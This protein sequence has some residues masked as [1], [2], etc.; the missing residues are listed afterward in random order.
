MADKST[1]LKIVITDAN[2]VNSTS[3]VCSTDADVKNMASPILDGILD[4]LGSQIND[5][6][7]S[8]AGNIFNG[9]KGKASETVI[10]ELIS[11]LDDEEKSEIA[12]TGSSNIRDKV[13]VLISVLAFCASILMAIFAHDVKRETITPLIAAGSFWIAYVINLGLKW[14]MNFMDSTGGLLKQCSGKLKALSV[15]NSA[16]LYVSPI[17]AVFLLMNNDLS[18]D[19]RTEIKTCFGAFTGS[20]ILPY[21]YMLKRKCSK[22]ESTPPVLVAPMPSLPVQISSVTPAISS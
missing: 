10:V 1:D 16:Q 7:G 11:K 17:T 9:I 18:E 4:N 5:K 20:L 22:E 2:A 14:L 15:L 12:K 19:N 3:S 13:L 21:L 6:A 8:G